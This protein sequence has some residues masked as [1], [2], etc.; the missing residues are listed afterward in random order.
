MDF[1]FFTLEQNRLAPS[2]RDE[3]EPNRI[4][5]YDDVHHDVHMTYDEIRTEATL[6]RFVIIDMS[7]V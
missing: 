3:N 7:I 2:L 4:V 5:T 6:Q 1:Q